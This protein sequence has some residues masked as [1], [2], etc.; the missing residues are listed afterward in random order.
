MTMHFSESQ[1]VDLLTEIVVKTVEL[2]RD[3]CGSAVIKN[4][5]EYASMECRADIIR[6]LIPEAVLMSMHRTA[7]RVVEKAFNCCND[8]EQKLI[9]AALLEAKSPLSVVDIACSH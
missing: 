1:M 9:A 6:R 7:S 5:L 8:I 4:L 3:P 2:S